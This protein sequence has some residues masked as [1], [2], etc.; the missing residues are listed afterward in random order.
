MTQ[1]I[2]QNYSKMCKM[3]KFKR[4]NMNIQPRNKRGRAYQYLLKPIDFTKKIN[5]IAS[6]IIMLCSKRKIITSELVWLRIYLMNFT[7]GKREEKDRSQ[8][9]CIW[10]QMESIV[11]ELI[12]DRR[13]KKLELRGNK[14]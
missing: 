10:G 5:I 14:K 12:L 6:T 8:K 2:S 3:T 4:I 1:L 9:S 13:G 7:K 11:I